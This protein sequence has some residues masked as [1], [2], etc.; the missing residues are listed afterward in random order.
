V[1]RALGTTALGLYTL[2][3]RLPELLI[4]NL[5]VV[6][7]RVLFPAFAN[8]DREALGRAFLL[9][10][11]YTLMVGLP[12]A[13][14]LAILAKPTILAVFGGQWHG[15]I[16]P[17]QVLAVYALSVTVGIP[18]GTAFKA[19]GRADVLLKLAVPR[20]AMLV[21]ALLLFG[22]EGI[23]AVGACQAVTAVTFDT[24]ALALAARRFEVSL[25]GMLEAA[26]PAIA[27]T[28]VMSVVVGAIAL[29]VHSSWLALIASAVLGG[30]GYLA[31]VALLA[32]ESLR[33]LREIA[34]PR[35]AGPGEGA[36]PRESH[37]VA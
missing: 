22:K 8:V 35:S 31:S 26:W 19:I 32:P 37:L 11:R 36:P 21:V 3:F 30:V 16:S 17:M 34:F 29:T 12:L 25:R 10:L 4:L 27:G 28:A 2:A 24:I 23:L 15:S 5:S 13:A 20:L 6:T 33:S 14:G 1:G 18:G 9:S 7:G